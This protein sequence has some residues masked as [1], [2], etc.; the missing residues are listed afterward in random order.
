[1]KDEDYMPY[2]EE[3]KDEL[4]KLT[5]IHIIAL[6]RKRC[7]AYNELEE[8]LRWSNLDLKFNRIDP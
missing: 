2:G 7:L 6:Y 1:M 4:M 5:K 3:W 8:K